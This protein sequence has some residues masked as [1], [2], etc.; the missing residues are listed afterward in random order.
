MFCLIIAF[1]FFS[2]A[3]DA[4]VYEAGTDLK[5]R[6]VL[7]ILKPGDILEIGP[8]VYKGGILIKGLS[9]QRDNSITIKAKDSKNPPV[10]VG[11]NTT[12]NLSQCHN[13][14]LI[15]LKIRKARQNGIHVHDGNTGKGDTPPSVNI[16]LDGLV[17]EDIGPV[18]N[19]D[20]IKMSGVKSFV[21]KNCKISGWGGSGIDFVGCSNG[22]VTGCLFR[23][24]KG[25][26][27]GNGIQIKGGSHH[28]LV[29][30]CTFYYPGRRGINL[31][32]STGLKWFRPR[33]TDYE[34]KNIEVAGNIFIGGTAIAFVTSQR[35]YVHH[36]AILYPTGWVFRILQETWG[37]RFKPCSNGIFMKNIVVVNEQMK[38]FVNIGPGTYPESFRFSQNVWYDQS[39]RRTPQLP[40]IEKSPVYQVD[41]GVKFDNGKVFF[42]SKD[43][44]LIGMGPGYY[45]RR[46]QKF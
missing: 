6:D 8:G 24:K 27:Q 16:L 13:L 28:I 25:F 19:F 38:D 30:K 14:C 44:R 1:C 18:G 36:N 31:G 20:A 34:A 9:G 46:T 37:A 45:K 23:G 5:I 22:R 42:L 3:A 12:L 43:P 17:V 11:G 40:F 15:N 2:N 35:G 33:V 10:F 32:G 39:L 21:V 29:E 7:P 4:K 41:P 26:S